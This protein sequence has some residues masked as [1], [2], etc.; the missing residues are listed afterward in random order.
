MINSLRDK[1]KLEKLPRKQQVQVAVYAAE[2]VIPVTPI[3]VKSAAEMC[4][5]VAKRWLKSEATAEE[6]IQVGDYAAEECEG[7]HLPN[8]TVWIAANA[9]WMAAN[10]VDASVYWAIHWL[11]EVPNSEEIIKKVSAFCDNLLNMDNHIEEVF[12]TD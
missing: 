5:E 7:S 9:V 4:I 2:L 10:H 6:C 3:A 1:E 8:W 12:L 11:L